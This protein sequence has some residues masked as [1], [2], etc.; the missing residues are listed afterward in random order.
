MFKLQTY[1]LK[2]LT[3][4]TSNLTNEASLNILC[5]YCNNTGSLALESLCLCEVYIIKEHAFLSLSPLS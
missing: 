4:L 3:L 1:S 2:E 5:C